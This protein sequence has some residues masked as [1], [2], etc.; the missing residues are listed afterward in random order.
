MLI[1]MYFHAFAGADPILKLTLPHPMHWVLHSIL[2][3]DFLLIN[4]INESEM[5]QSLDMLLDACCR[6]S[7]VFHVLAGSDHNTSE[8][9]LQ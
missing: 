6:N 9:L 5:L 4:K 1:W 2:S 7:F 3:R 8:D